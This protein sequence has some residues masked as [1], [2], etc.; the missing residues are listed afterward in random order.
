M[1]PA[2]ENVYICCGDYYELKIGYKDMFYTAYISAIDYPKVSSRSW[3]TSHKKNKVY[4]ISGNTHTKDTVYLHNFVMNFVYSEN[5][6]YEVDHING[7]SLD[8]RRENLRIF[9]RQENI[10]N[11]R[12]RS[13]NQIGIRGISYNKSNNK[14]KCDFSNRGV[15]IYF[16][17]FDTLA[18]AVYCRYFI[19]LF[20]S[21]DI[22]SDNPMVEQY[23][24]QLSEDQK[25]Q[26]EKYAIN[27]YFEC[28]GM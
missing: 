11:T 12:V 3:R 21:I 1:R 16:R 20:C 4:V 10:E 19:E 13:D 24:S 7:N 8:N 15:R 18:E 26:I 23:I 9:S 25:H 6:G 22:A 27:K 5:Y 28:N 14:Y 17:D 2:K